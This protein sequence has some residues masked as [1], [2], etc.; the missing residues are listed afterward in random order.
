[1]K[2]RKAHKKSNF[3]V[4]LLG[5]TGQYLFY[6]YNTTEINFLINNLIRMVER[7]R[8]TKGVGDFMESYNEL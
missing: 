7:A 1:M 3:F 8:A 6:N 5:F 2:N 4:S